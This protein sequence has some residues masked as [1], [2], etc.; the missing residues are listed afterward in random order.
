MREA[1]GFKSAAAFCRAVRDG[2]LPVRLFEMPG[3]RGRF[4]LATDV[5]EWLVTRAEARGHPD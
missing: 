1:L 2:R 4:A 5:S 3:R